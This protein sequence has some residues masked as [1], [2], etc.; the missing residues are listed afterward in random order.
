MGPWGVALHGPPGGVQPHQDGH[1]GRCDGAAGQDVAAEE[2][3]RGVGARGRPPVGEAPVDAA[4]RAVG[5]RAV[6]APARQRGRRKQQGVR[7]G[8]DDQHEAV[9]RAEAVACKSKI[10]K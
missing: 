5:L 4:G 8:A 9:A 6:L 2:E 10:K 7:P 3:R 1:V